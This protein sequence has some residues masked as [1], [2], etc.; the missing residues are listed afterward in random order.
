M[1]IHSFA[2]LSVL[3]VSILLVGSS[4]FLFLPQAVRAW[5]AWKR[6]HNTQAFTTSIF[7][8]FIVLLALVPVYSGWL[9]IM[10][11]WCDH[12]SII[13]EV[14]MLFG[15]ALLTFRVFLPQTALA[16]RKYATTHSYKYLGLAGV[17]FFISSALMLTVGLALYRCHLSGGLD[18]I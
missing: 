17:F 18:A 6:E 10:W 7:F 15:L 4:A 13:T 1:A 3:C 11:Q 16:Y 14:F 12:Q 2:V 9:Y 5:T 8:F